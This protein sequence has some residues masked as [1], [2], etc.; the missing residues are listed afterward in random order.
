M[1]SAHPFRQLPEAAISRIAWRLAP[2]LLAVLLGL[3][4]L[5]RGGSMWRDESVTWQVAHRPLGGI[6][7]LLG[8]VDAVHG[9]YYLLMHGVFQLWDGGLWA[10][11]LPSVAATA[12]AAAGVAAVAHRLCGER[13]ALASGCV[14]AVLPPVQMYA[15]EGRSYALVAAAVVW[16]TYLML[17]ERW[18]AY[19]AV[20]V[21]GCWLHEFAAL[22]LLAHAFPSR[23][24]R[25]WRR[26][27]AVVALLILPLAVLSLRQAH[28]QLGWLGRP[29]WQDWTAYGLLATTALLLSRGAPRTLVGVALP[30][31]LLPPGLLMTISL[32]NPWYVDR[33]VLYALTGWT[34]LAGVRLAGVCSAGQPAGGP[35]AG[36]LAVSD[37]P[38][39]AQTA[40]DPAE[41][42]RPASDPP[43]SDPPEGVRLGA[44]QPAGAQPAS[45][46]PQGSRLAE[47]QRAGVPA[48]GARHA[49]DPPAGVLAAGRRLGAAQGAGTKPAAARIGRAQP[50]EARPASDRPAGAQ[51]ASVGLAGGGLGEAQPAGTTP[52]GVGLGRPEADQPEEARP[53]S[54]R[55]AGAQF[56]TTGLTGGDLG[57]AEP[58]GAG[59]AGARLGVAQGVG[60]RLVGV[61]AAGGRRVAV[62][63]MLVRLVGAWVGQAQGRGHPETRVRR[64]WVWGLAGAVLVAGVG[65]W[66]VWLRTAES[67]KDDVLAVAAAV[68]EYARPG[69]AVVF[70]P[71]RRREWLLS[72]P[73]TYADLHDAALSGSPAASHS[74]QGTELPPERIR[75]ALLAAPRVIALLDPADQPLDPYPRE[76]IKREL[77]ATHFERC[78]I[79]DVRGARIALYAHPGTCP[80]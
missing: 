21:L 40:G 13:A 36:V 47:A 27:A 66:S 26:S 5:E 46:L 54:D 4:G 56:G 58:A 60:M 2:P 43:A 34:L 75:A 70:M 62:P 50:A 24:S 78:S 17:R 9:L 64:P 3:W 38:A 14:Y 23:H 33:Y 65:V 32:A 42:A 29:S 67:R 51:F 48:E 71:S 49:S 73:G 80:R 44:G 20:L 61:L 16:A 19:T 77:L 35:P 76:A 63:L 11:R 6:A 69:D 8:R 68:R 57:E 1:E 37:P 12:L 28:D 30:L 55:P 39:G 79:T 31:T 45:G 22:A 10:L 7:E 72:S 18:A 25:A 59:S 53:A 41:G 52:A 74:L 15:Q